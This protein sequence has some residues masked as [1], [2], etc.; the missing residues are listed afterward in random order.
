M[1]ATWENVET[2]VWL[3][4]LEDGTYA[5]VCGGCRRRLYRGYSYR[6]ASRTAAE[7]DCGR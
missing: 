3:V 5:V 4:E 1:P 6:R 7:H 2:A